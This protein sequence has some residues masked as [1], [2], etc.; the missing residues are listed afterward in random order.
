MVIEFIK[1]KK[2]KNVEEEEGSSTVTN[3]ERDQSLNR[4]LARCQT[5]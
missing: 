2:K 1:V 3:T 4:I 5:K